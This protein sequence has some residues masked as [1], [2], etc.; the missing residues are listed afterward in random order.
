MLMTFK[1]DTVNVYLEWF[2]WVTLALVLPAFALIGARISELRAKLSANN[3]ELVNALST[4]QVLANHD[5]LTGLPNRAMFNDNL[6]QA[7]AR[8]SRPPA[9]LN[10]ICSTRCASPPRSSASLRDPTIA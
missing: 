7:I 1:P 4:I 5:S 2:Q 6:Q 8:A 3:A 10:T 9:P